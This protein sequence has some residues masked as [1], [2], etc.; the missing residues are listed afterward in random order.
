MA[1]IWF[2]TGS[3][4]GLGRA[5]V[6]AALTRGDKVAASARNVKDVAPLT[7]TYGDAVLPLELD[8]RNR[9]AAVAALG[10][11]KMKFGRIDVVVNNAARALSCAVEE[12]QEAEAR[13]VIETNLLGT[14][15]V[16]QAA[17]PIMREQGSGH[18]VQITSG[19]GVI[20]WPMNGVYQSSKFGIDG[21]SESL[22]Q[23]AKHL[24][25]KVTIMQVGHMSDTGLGRTAKSVGAPIAAYDPMRASMAQTSGRRGNTPKD[26]TEKILKVVDSKHPP[27]RV[28][29]GR[30]LTDIKVAYEERLKLWAEWETAR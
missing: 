16:T 11:A 12:A 25:I 3:G 2:V 21:M 17:L 13:D 19:G 22:A 6:E 28:L 1:K 26:L 5:I 10:T 24:G 29:V 7:A 30:P 20:S 4:Q 15:W 23:E 9:T 18:V 14:L 27:L 8:V